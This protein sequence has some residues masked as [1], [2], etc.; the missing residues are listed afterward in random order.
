ML[1]KLHQQEVEV[2][3]ELHQPLKGQG[4]EQEQ[5]QEALE[6]IAELRQHLLDESLAHQKC[7]DELLHN[8]LYLALLGLKSPLLRYQVFFL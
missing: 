6:P 3:E 4:Q 8:L 5:E 7:L 1:V 2:V